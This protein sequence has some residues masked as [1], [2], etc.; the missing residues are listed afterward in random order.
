MWYVKI[1]CLFALILVVLLFGFANRD[2]VMTIKWWFT[3][4]AQSELNVALALFGVYG[5]GVL[6]FFLISI[7]REMR[8]RR[9][10]GVLERETERLRAELNALRI[11]PLEDPIPEDEES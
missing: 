11:A 10:C 3:E 1:F 8:L 9:R 2:E 4:T 6:T 5:L 7:V